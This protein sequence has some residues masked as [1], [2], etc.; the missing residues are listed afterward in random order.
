MRL[1]YDALGVLF[2]LDHIFSIAYSC[3]LIRG[4]ELPWAWGGTLFPL[5]KPGPKKHIYLIGKIRM[6][7]IKRK[8]RPKSVPK[9]SRGIQWLPKGKTK[10]RGVTKNNTR[11]HLMLNQ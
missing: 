6:V 5:K 8:G 2:G 11:S 3:I 7:Y 9:H 1:K 4:V 10:K